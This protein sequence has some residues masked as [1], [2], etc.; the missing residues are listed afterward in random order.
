MNEAEELCNQGLELTYEEV[1]AVLEYRPEVEGSCLVWRANRGVRK[2]K[3]RRAGCMDNRYWR[4]RFKGKNHLAH[5][6]VW[7]L[8]YGAMPHRNLDHIDGDSYNNNAC[9]LR[10]TPNNQTEN[11]QNKAMQTNNTSGYIGVDWHKATK[12]WRG[13]IK[14]NGV[15]HCLGYFDTPEE[16]HAAYIKAKAE[17][18]T[19][20]PTLRAS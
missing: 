13:R 1:A 15:N 19:F 7:L 6:L 5:R 12:K 16:A 2:I 14:A 17:L 3:G 18:H 11:S 10:L 8:V 20:Q 4:V 9:N